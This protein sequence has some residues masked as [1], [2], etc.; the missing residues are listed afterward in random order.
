[1]QPILPQ[2]SGPRNSAGSASGRVVVK[3][4]SEDI[5]R[6]TTSQGDQ[7]QAHR[8]AYKRDRED[9]LR[10]YRRRLAEAHPGRFQSRDE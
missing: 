9:L 3:M 2:R 5:G 8:A 10:K 4:A 6:P 1:P 7:D